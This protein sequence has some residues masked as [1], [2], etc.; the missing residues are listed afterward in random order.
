MSKTAFTN[1]TFIARLA[2]YGL[3]TSVISLTKANG[4]NTMAQLWQGLMSNPRS[5]RTM[6]N[7]L[8]AFYKH[9]GFSKQISNRIS[10]A[11][12]TPAVANISKYDGALIRTVWS[13]PPALP[14]LR[15]YVTKATTKASRRVAKPTSGLVS[16]KQ[17][18]PVANRV[19]R[20][21]KRATKA[22]APTT[23]VGEAIN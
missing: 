23:Q 12:G 3:P 21:T 16:A 14:A 7:I 18:K 9:N 5:T 20:T 15:H 13:Q 17:A 22:A 8:T 2:A 11:G 6:R 1:A 19:R 10:K 4:Y